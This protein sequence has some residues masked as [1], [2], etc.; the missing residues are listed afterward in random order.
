LRP[1]YHSKSSKDELVTIHEVFDQLVYKPSWFMIKPNKVRVVVDIGAFIGAFTL[2][3]KVQWPK[4]TIH[5]YEP[6]PTSFKFLIKNIKRAKLLKKVK[7]HCAAVW[8]KK[9]SYPR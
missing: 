8:G 5:A 9:R 4:A 1:I 7:A 6:D 2:W 3:A